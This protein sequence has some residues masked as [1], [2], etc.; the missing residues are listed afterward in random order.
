M[1]NDTRFEF[2]FG[3]VKIYGHKSLPGTL[4]QILKDTLVARV[5]G[6]RK[7]EF[8]RGF[9]CFT[10]LLNRQYSPVIC[11]RMDDHGRI[12]SGFNDLVKVTQRA[13]SYSVCQRTINPACFTTDY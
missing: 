13:H 5:V 1:G 6:N 12:L 11:Q 8:P 2:S 9:D 4:F 10:C 7:A 3:V